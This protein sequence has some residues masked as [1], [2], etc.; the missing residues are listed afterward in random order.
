[1]ALLR[2]KGVLL[3]QAAA[4]GLG[5][6]RMARSS[7][8]LCCGAVAEQRRA[9]RHEREAPAERHSL[10]VHD[11]ALPP[12]HAHNCFSTVHEQ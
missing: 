8:R 2:H 10:Q 7:A 4:I 6:N 1:M 5:T 11:T 12:K 9:E 3:L